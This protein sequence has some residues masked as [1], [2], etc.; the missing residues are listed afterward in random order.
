MAEQLIKTSLAEIMLY[1]S[2]N[3]DD[4]LA[5]QL[6]SFFQ[7][8]GSL[9]LPLL[10]ASTKA[11]RLAMMSS[12][13]ISKKLAWCSASVWEA[14][15]ALGLEDGIELFRPEDVPSL[16][17]VESLANSV[18]QQ[19]KGLQCL[20][21]RSYNLAYHSQC[22]QM[23]NDVESVDRA[24][25]GWKVASRKLS[26]MVDELTT[27]QQSFVRLEVDMAKTLLFGR[28]L[29]YL[30]DGL[31]KS[32]IDQ[33]RHSVEMRAFIKQRCHFVGIV[34]TG[35][36]QSNPFDQQEYQ[37]TA[38]ALVSL[39][40]GLPL[41]KHTMT[42]NMKQTQTT[43]LPTFYGLGYMYEAAMTVLRGNAPLLN[44]MAA[45]SCDIGLQNV[46]NLFQSILN[47]KEEESVNLGIL[48]AQVERDCI[49]QDPLLQGGEKCPNAGSLDSLSMFNNRDQWTCMPSY[50]L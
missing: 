43:L 40:I 49:L 5:M 14:C 19:D 2:H 25:L 37:R 8:S 32:T 26:M 27:A 3:D 28:A 38:E 34:S 33:L 24:L 39:L 20:L 41:G 13:T 6:I 1:R 45:E 35:E 22:W 30:M 15:I 29:S 31:C 16:D 11:A 23:M 42:V 36:K 21:V 44:W 4:L 50:C 9:S 48:C 10:A 7:V 46:K 47:N 17:F 18:D 12:D